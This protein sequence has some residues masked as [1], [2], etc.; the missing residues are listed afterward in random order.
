MKKLLALLLAL[1]MVFSFAACG[2]KP[3]APAEP[4]TKI[5][6]IKAAGKLVVG[7]SAD[8]P[9]YEFHTEINGE[10]KIVGFDMAFAQLLADELGVELEL[11]DMAFDGLL[12]SLQKGDFDMVIAGLTPTE[13]RKKVIDFAEPFYEN[14]Q[15]VII[16][17]A[18]DSKINTTDDCANLIGAYQTGNIQ[19]EFAK[20]FCGEENCIALVKFQDLIMELK[21]GKV[22]AI[23]TNSLTGAAYASG[24]DDIMIKDINITDEVDSSAVAIQK[25]N[26]DLVDFV[27]DIVAKCKAEGTIDGFIDEA[28][29]LAGMN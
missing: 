3:D 8:F 5:D 23:F 17:K 15:I 4:M 10:D 24:N 26:E 1:A 28:V 21:T 13:E 7:T 6:Q 18:D 22:D 20:R 2:S 12:I 25:G 11:V 29:E 14:E 27:N 16:R 9:P 19:E